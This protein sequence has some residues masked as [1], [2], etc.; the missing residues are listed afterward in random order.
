MATA[1]LAEIVTNLIKCDSE[2]EKFA[3]D[4]VIQILCVGSQLTN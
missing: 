1:K 4:E 2:I 3:R